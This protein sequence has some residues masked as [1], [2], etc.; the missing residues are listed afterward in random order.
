MFS[1]DQIPNFRKCPR[2]EEHSYECFKTHSYC[3]NCNYS[4]AAQS[5]LCVI[6]RWVDQALKEK[7]SASSE[8][9]SKERE[10]ALALTL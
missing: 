9:P 6:P 4:T 2:C 5:E 7:S 10:L 1:D 3:A 8:R